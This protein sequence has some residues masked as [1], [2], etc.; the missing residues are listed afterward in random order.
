M[1]PPSSSVRP[2]EG[3]TPAE[4]TAVGA[5]AEGGGQAEAEAA[6]EVGA[7]AAAA[8]AEAVGAAGAAEAAAAVEVEAAAAA[9]E[10]VA[11][12]GA[13]EAVAAEEAAVAAEVRALA[14]SAPGDWRRPATPRG[15]PSDRQLPQ[16]AARSVRAFRSLNGD[17][18]ALDTALFE[19]LPK[20]AACAAR[21]GG[22][23]RGGRTPA[24]AG[25]RA[26]GAP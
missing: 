4:A 25:C 18:R 2:P 16:G 19:A 5:E 13:A 3:V 26:G 20:P 10:G 24:R 17:R 22:F 23:R 6:V 9:A 15:P 21:R 11:A 7:P 1:S 12:V 14:T 8:G